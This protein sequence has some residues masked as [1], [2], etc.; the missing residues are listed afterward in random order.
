V[1]AGTVADAVVEV[2]TAAVVLAPSADAVGVVAVAAGAEVSATVEV[3]SALEVVAAAVGEL[4][5]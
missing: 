1:V 3:S 4:G 2:T 5:G